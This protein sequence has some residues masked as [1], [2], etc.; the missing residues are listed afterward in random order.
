MS[1]I[2]PNQT[3][4][5]PAAGNAAINLVFSVV[6][7]MAWARCV[8]EV[9]ELNVADALG[10]GA[11]TPAELAQKIGVS[12]NALGRV[13]RYLAT[14]GL[15][16]DL[17]GRF[18]HNELSRYLRNDHPMSIRN[19]VRLG[20]GWTFWGLLGHT[21]RTGRPAVEAIEPGGLWEY[22]VKNP[23]LAQRFD[24]SMTAKSRATSAAI[25][26]LYDFSGFG[27]IADIGGSQGYLIETILD[28]TPNAKGILFDL[29]HVIEGAHVK[30][31]SRLTLQGG[32]FFKDPLPVADA[33][34]MM[35]VIHDWND[36]ESID[37]LTAVRKVA[38]SS[39]KLLLVE[40]LMPETPKAHP[41]VVLD[42]VMM[43]YSTGE[44]RKQ[45]QYEALLKSA[46]F[47][48]NR[49]IPLGLMAMLEATPI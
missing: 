39:S 6:D 7:S 14:K 12:T 27:T 36:E 8:I 5:A 20:M 25:A 4:P 22:L 1:S 33:Y 16:E 26:K 10:E 43:A 46:D 32:D 9:A 18:R 40:M 15:F 11:E 19:S 48:L 31:S 47:R 42:L 41:S 29:P 30:G 23:E 2:Q 35:N 34:L 3:Q 44:E 13:M 37:I 28:A 45:S 21:L 49:V 17:D 24:E 38:P